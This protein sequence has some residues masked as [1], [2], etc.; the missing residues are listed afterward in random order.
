M[1]DIAQ[2]LEQWACT[3]SKGSRIISSLSAMQKECSSIING[4]LS[5]LDFSYIFLFFN[6]CYTIETVSQ[7]KTA[8]MNYVNY[9]AK[10]VD[11]YHTK[12]VGWT[13]RDFISPFDIHTVD[14]IRLL[15]EALQC[16]S[17]FWM[18]MSK[19]EVNRHKIDL[20]KRRAAGETIG[21]PRQPRSDRGTKRP[22]KM[23]PGVNEGVDDDDPP[24]AKKQKKGTTKKTRDKDVTQSKKQKK[25]TTK[26]TPKKSKKSKLPPARPTSNEFISSE[27]DEV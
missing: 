15:L 4:T 1:W 9:D 21:K 18:R 12:L 14:D 13:Y 5:K 27:D 3:K 11:W 17:C 10:V 20:E 16:G 24:P 23:A 25:V 8:L 7:A 26:K 2:L 22:R 19:I 6:C